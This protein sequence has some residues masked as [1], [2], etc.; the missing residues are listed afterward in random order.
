M[1]ELMMAAQAEAR[2]EA[3]QAAK[4]EEVKTTKTFGS[5]FKKGFLGGGSK[6][7]KAAK[8]ASKSSEKQGTPQGDVPIIRRT[9]PEPSAF[10]ADVQKAMEDSKSPVL[11][12][13]EQGG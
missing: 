5:G 1:L 2:K 10:A 4:A 9:A 8:P 3:Q 12:K 11:K 6:D 7:A 13:L